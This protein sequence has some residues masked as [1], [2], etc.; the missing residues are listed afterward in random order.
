MLFFSKRASL[1]FL[2]RFSPENP[3]VDFQN[4]DGLFGAII[5]EGKATYHE[6]RT[7]YTLEDALLIYEVI[8]VTRVNEY[9]AA[10][11][12][13]KQAKQRN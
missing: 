9:L 7:V 6:L 2:N 1:D 3:S 10:K 8:A 11:E 12:A 4:I 5:A 13:Q